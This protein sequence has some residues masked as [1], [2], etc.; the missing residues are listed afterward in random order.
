MSNL[1]KTRKMKVRIITAGVLIL[2]SI[3]FYFSTDTKN[4]D[5]GNVVKHYNLEECFYS[6]TVG[7]LTN[8]TRIIA[9]N[10]DGFKE[11]VKFPNNIKVDEVK[12]DNKDVIV[13]SGNTEYIFVGK[14]QCDTPVV[15]LLTNDEEKIIKNN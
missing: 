14:E 9:F 10:Q 8:S 3:A 12:I 15:S 4:T 11:V 7:D 1:I 6:M 5:S 2:S 13:I